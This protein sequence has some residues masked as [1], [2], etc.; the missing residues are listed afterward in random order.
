MVH[1]TCCKRH[2]FY[3]ARFPSIKCCFLTF[4]K[5]FEIR[6][7]AVANLKQSSTS[8][9]PHKYHVS[10]SLQEFIEK[11]GDCEG[12]KWL[13]DVVSVAG[14]CVKS[15]HDFKFVRVKNLGY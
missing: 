6:S 1:C 10:I 2:A 5:Y 12:G 3:S 13:D 9:Y 11:Y 15:Y 7:N 8:P 4:K 14:M